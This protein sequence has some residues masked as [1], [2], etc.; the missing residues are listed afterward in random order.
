MTTI[1]FDG[2]TVAADRLVDEWMN[3]GKL[4]KLKDG[5]I[6]TGAGFYDQVVEVVAWLKRGGGESD[7]PALAEG[8]DQDS[9]ILVIHPDGKAYWLTWPYLRPVL[10]RDKFIA[11]GSGAK[12]ALG[13]MAAGADARR[14]VQIACRF[15]PASGKGVDS[16]RIVKTKPLPRRR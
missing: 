15:D 4:F 9:D 12:L 7:R 5:R 8:E 10:V 3:V 6:V 2:K 13:A 1:A 14:A 16:V 11:V